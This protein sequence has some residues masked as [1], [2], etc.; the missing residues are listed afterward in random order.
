MAMRP[1]VKILRPLVLL[2]LLMKITFTIKQVSYVP[3]RNLP[4][5]HLRPLKP[6]AQ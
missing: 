4:A 1:F 5:S 6:L 3:Q 2:L